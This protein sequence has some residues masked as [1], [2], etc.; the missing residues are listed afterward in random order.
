LL[1]EDIRVAG[2][3]A[4]AGD[5]SIVPGTCRELVSESGFTNITLNFETEE[6]KSQVKSTI[7]ILNYHIE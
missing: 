6:T 4:M 5:G 3:L 7:P 2:A 1:L